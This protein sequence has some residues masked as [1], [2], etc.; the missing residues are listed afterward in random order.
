MRSVRTRGAGVTA[1]PRGKPLWMLR[2][3][4][5]RRCWTACRSDWCEY[6]LAVLHSGLRQQPLIAPPAGALAVVKRGGSWR[7][8]ARARLTASWRGGYQ[9]NV[10]TP[11]LTI[12][13]ADLTACPMKFHLLHIT[14]TV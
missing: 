1:R 5:A 11:N 4:R 3:W 12:S 7:A 10:Q 14:Q 2:R 6:L 8:P 9:R 13:S